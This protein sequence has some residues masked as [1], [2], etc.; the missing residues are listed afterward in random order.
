MSG[1]SGNAEDFIPLLSNKPLCLF[2]PEDYRTYIRG[3]KLQH[4]VRVKKER[5]PLKLS[6]KRLKKGGLSVR[7]KR[8]PP[9]VTPEEFADLRKGIPENELFI[10]LKEKGIRTMSHEEARKTKVVFP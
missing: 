1:G 10:A 6:V 3:L 2:T 4:K 5:K 7:T 9:Y 8:N